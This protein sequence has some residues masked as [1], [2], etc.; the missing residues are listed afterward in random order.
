[1]VVVAT[2]SSCLDVATARSGHL[3]IG[4]GTYIDG[5]I[6]IIITAETVVGAERTVAP[7]LR[8]VLCGVAFGNE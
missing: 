7:S 6:I 1:M 8:I 4:V 3:G 2:S 5:S